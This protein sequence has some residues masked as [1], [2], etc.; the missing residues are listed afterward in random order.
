MAGARP[1]TFKKSGGFLNNVDGLIADYEFTTDRPGGGEGK[2]KKGSDFIPLYFR[3]SAR[4]DGADEDDQTSIFVGGSTDFEISDDGKT[5]TPTDKDGGL[6][7]NSDLSFFINSLV[8]AGFPEANLSEDEINFE[9]IVGTRVRFIQERDEEATKRLGKR[10][11]KDGKKE[12]DRTRL[13]IS[14]VYA[15]PGKGAGKSKAKAADADDDVVA[16]TA[17]EVV[18]AILEAQKD[19]AISKD[20]LSVVVLQKMLKHKQKA[21]KDEVREWL[22]DDDN[23]SGIEGVSYNA[24]KEVLTLDSDE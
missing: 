11:S 17:V 22:S 16:E 9:S 14:K 18:K 21:L 8:V 20:K 3:L 19:N 12:Y 23:L 24:K 4:V 13:A 2:A 15:L 6:R 5:I 7:D 1:S 10:K